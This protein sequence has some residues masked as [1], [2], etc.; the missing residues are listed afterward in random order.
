MVSWLDANFWLPDFTELGGNLFEMIQNITLQPFILYPI[1][2]LYV[3]LVLAQ[4]LVGFSRITVRRGKGI[5]KKMFVGS[6][7]WWINFLLF[8]ITFVGITVLFL[9][10]P[11]YTKLLVGG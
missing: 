11:F 2:F 1:I 8:N 4:L 9:F 7:L 5:R 3:S 10:L 6:G